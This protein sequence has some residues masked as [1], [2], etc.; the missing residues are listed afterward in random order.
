MNS[1]L[2]ASLMSIPSIHEK[3]G[4]GE[5]AA[6]GRS[7]T[8]TTCRAGWVSV[9]RRHPPRNE[10]GAGFTTFRETNTYIHVGG[11]V[12]PLSFYVHTRGGKMIGLRTNK[13]PFQ[14]PSF[15]QLSNASHKI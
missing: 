8:C 13:M 10:K 14:L 11:A 5:S 6:A 4:R 9:K 15:P 1:R 2:V 12:M 7:P 3:R